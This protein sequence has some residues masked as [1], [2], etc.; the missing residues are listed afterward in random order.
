MLTY[1]SARPSVRLSLVGRF[2]LASGLLTLLIG[3]LSG[4]YGVLIAGVILAML[5]LV[6][7]L[8]AFINI[9]A[10]VYRR[11]M[12]GLVEKGAA[13][14]VMATLENHKPWVGSFGVEV[15]DA[16]PSCGVMRPY[17]AGVLP[18]QI[19]MA[20]VSTRLPERG[21]V[22]G[23]PYTMRSHFPIGLV[24]SERR[25]V[26]RDI[27]T[28]YPAACEPDWL[29]RVL[30]SGSGQGGNSVAAG[31]GIGEFRSMREYRPGDSTRLIS[32]PMSSRRNHLVVRE[33]DIP[34][35]QHVTLIFHS[36]R[37]QG[38]VLARQGFEESLSLLCGISRG[39]RSRQI[40]L[41]VVAPFTEWNQYSIQP[42]DMAASNGF[43]SLLAEAKLTP[44]AMLEPVEEAIRM[45]HGTAHTIWVL[46]NT[47]RRFWLHGLAG[48]QVPFWAVDNAGIQP[49]ECVS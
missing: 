4:V 26:S 38:T 46:S 49:V 44:T 31:E 40:P 9:Q 3:A 36:Y 10:L 8:F 15:N 45:Y 25:G 11:D 12:P 17:F 14:G 2:V 1:A 37:P 6:S 7:M 5:P 28:V 27:I 18:R 13:V 23:S 30:L 35:P 20:W 41:T 21:I 33:M 19:S 42:D 34:T 43:L 47:P 24:K 39:L 29:D 22:N 32:W 48:V 16:L